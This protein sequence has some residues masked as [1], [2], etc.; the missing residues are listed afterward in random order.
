MQKLTEELCITEM[1]TQID[2]HNYNLYSDFED[3]IDVL[4]GMGLVNISRSGPEWGLSLPAI[5]TA[6]RKINK[7][8]ENQNLTF[9]SKPGF[10]HKRKMQTLTVQ[11]SVTKQT[12]CLICSS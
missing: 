5:T 7:T 6:P 1:R 4:C 3:P 12:F 9:P 2:L 8:T 10:P 11:Q